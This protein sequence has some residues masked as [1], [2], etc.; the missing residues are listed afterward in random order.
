MSSARS[1]SN[2]T[3]APAHLRTEA[4]NLQ[5][6]AFTATSDLTHLAEDEPFKHISKVGR[7]ETAPITIPASLWASSRDAP[8]LT[9]RDTIFATTYVQSRSPPPAQDTH[10]GN[11]LANV[12]KGLGGATSGKVKISPRASR[13]HAQV[14]FATGTEHRYSD[15]KKVQTQQPEVHELLRDTQIETTSNKG[16]SMGIEGAQAETSRRPYLSSTERPS[17][18]PAYIFDAVD[19]A[20]RARY[21]SWREGHTPWLG[22][23]SLAKRRSRSGDNTHVDKNIEATLRKID[24]PAISSR[25][26][27]SSQY[28]GLFKEKDVAEQKQRRDQRAKEQ[29]QASR[30]HQ[31][32]DQIRASS[33][34]AYEFPRDDSAKQVELT[35]EPEELEPS[36][37]TEY[38]TY[39]A[40]SHGGPHNIRGQE[41]PVKLPRSNTDFSLETEAPLPIPTRKPQSLS[42]RLVEEMKHVHDIELSSDSERLLSCSFQTK[43]MDRPRLAEPK[44]RTPTKEYANYIEPRESDESTGKSPVTED[45][46]ISEHE[47]ISKALYF[48]HRQLVTDDEEDYQRESSDAAVACA[49]EEAKASDEP[50]TP[51]TEQRLKEASERASNEVAL[52]LETSNDKEY[53]HGDLSTSLTLP[54]EDES[55]TSSNDLMYSGSEYDTQDESMRSAY[56]DTSSS[57]EAGSTPK[58]SPKHISTRKHITSAPLGAVELK[59]YDH[60]VGGHSTV[61]R[62]SRRAICKQLNNRENIFYEIVERWHPELVAF[63]P[64]YIGVL[65]VTY[66]KAIKRRKTVNPATPQKKS[67]LDM[68]KESVT[69]DAVASGP[70][71]G[72]NE[73][74][75]PQPRIVSHS[76]QITPVPQV[77]LENNRH[78][79][80]NSLFR[81]SSRPSTPRPQSSDPSL[82]SQMRRWSQSEQNLTHPES[83][84]ADT[85]PSRPPIKQQSS[86]GATTV[87]TKLKEQVLREV[88]A[89]PPIHRHRRG[90]R[91][92]SLSNTQN[93]HAQQADGTESGSGSRK[94]GSD[95]TGKYS[96]FTEGESLRRQLLRGEHA[97]NGLTRTTSAAVSD[98]GPAVDERNRDSYSDA[99]VEDSGPTEDRKS[100]RRHSGGGLRRRPFAIDSDKRSSL[101]FHEE[102]EEGY[103]GDREEEVFLMDDDDQPLA[104][105]HQAAQS[106]HVQNG[107]SGDP[108]PKP[109]SSHSL[110]APETRDQETQTY[111]EFFE[112]SNPKQAIVDKDERVQLFILLEDLTA[113]MSK[114]CVLDLKM[115]TRQYGVEADAKKKRSQRRKC[116]ST[117]SQELGVR[118]CGM[119]IFNVKTQSVVFKDKYYGRDLKAGREFQE[120]LKSFFFDGYGY[121]SALKHIP[122]ILEK[123]SSLE[124]MIHGLP[125]YRFYASSLLMLYDRAASEDTLALEKATAS[126]KKD[127]SKL[128]EALK[129]KAEI[130]LKIVDF[131]NC[132][133]A[134]DPPP[135]D[136]PCPPHDPE[137]ID[138]GYLRGL[139]TL[140]LYFQRIWKELNGTDWLERG[141]M[142]GVSLQSNGTGKDIKDF[143]DPAFSSDDEGN[144]SF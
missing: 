132:V 143:E 107:N 118:V 116:Q 104:S 15:S 83:M 141:D 137:G 88:F 105:S 29:A 64:R 56:Y 78:I 74:P 122:T 109:S 101:E 111:E 1:D 50:L 131:A 52:S 10:N 41:L 144:A 28:L 32:T 108:S 31:T 16:T 92:R 43:R 103:G 85:S 13:K 123:I 136:V 36:P 80:P 142:E 48:P 127:R 60:Q 121:S 35:A 61:Y 87:N 110:T 20:E 139:R 62:F 76:Q 90:R 38:G 97:R 9:E 58:A 12:D 130:K 3:S 140:R 113:G 27:K 59:P 77:V 117:T 8:Q 2:N 54:I 119:Q 17:T 5:K 4:E 34:L 125:G 114:P 129:K 49:I 81:A 79:I 134:E 94:G 102:E 69:Q 21:R 73:R 96:S 18:S 14:T 128:A 11:L 55:Y 22:S 46:E 44:S 19:E 135:A 98:L 47:Q 25:S 91:H 71:S 95:R 24:A 133:T 51:S 112:P 124:A 42:S 99:T 86:W 23:G 6:Q 57:D 33:P 37:R 45:D 39:M 115:G 138:R 7:S 68:S 82:L 126:D 66:R 40:L 120:A 106:Q 100:R 53:F 72:V 26:R 75:G 65:N 63:M 70:A 30:K 93:L 84:S 67:S 89:A